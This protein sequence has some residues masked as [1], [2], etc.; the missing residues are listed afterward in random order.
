MGHHIWSGS[1]G[2]GADTIF[3][4]LSSSTEGAPPYF[5][6]GNWIVYGFSHIYR[7]GT[8]VTDLYCYRLDNDAE[9]VK[10]GKGA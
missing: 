7:P 5:V 2:L 8:W 3:I 6:A 10:V 1:E 9:A 4:T